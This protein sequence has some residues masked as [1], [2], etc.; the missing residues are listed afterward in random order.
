MKGNKYTIKSGSVFSNTFPDNYYPYPIEEDKEIVTGEVVEDMDVKIE[1][2]NR[3]FIDNMY[4]FMSFYDNPQGIIL[5][6]NQ[7]GLNGKTGESNGGGTDMDN[8]QW[9]NLPSAD[10]QLN[11]TYY[12]QQQPN[13][14]ARH[15][16]ENVY[17]TNLHATWAR[18]GRIASIIEKEIGTFKQDFEGIKLCTEPLSPDA[19]RE[20]DAI[21]EREELLFEIKPY[22]EKWVSDRAKFPDQA[23]PFETPEEVIEFKTTG[24]KDYFA[25]TFLKIAVDNFNNQCWVDYSSKVFM[26][27]RACD[28]TG[29]WHVVENGYNKVKFPQPYNLIVDTR[30]DND[31]LGYDSM[32]AGAI[33]QKTL[34][35]I[36]T[37]YPQFDDEDRKLLWSLATESNAGLGL[38]RTSMC[39]T[40]SWYVYNA[41]YVNGNYANMTIACATV[42]WIAPK[43]IEGNMYQ[44]VYEGTI[45]G[46]RFMVDF[47]ECD[48]IIYN[49]YKTYMPMLPLQI[50]KPNFLLGRFN[51]AIGKIRHLQDD[52]DRLRFK[53]MEMIGKADG[54]IAGIYAAMLEGTDMVTIETQIKQYGFFLLGS[55]GQAISANEFHK[56]MEVWDKRLDPGFSQLTA[57]RG[58]INKEIEMYEGQT[59]VTLGENSKYIGKDAYN[60]SAQVGASGTYN[61]YGMT[62]KF[63]QIQLDYELN[64]KANLYANGF[65]ED[66]AEN[67]IGKK[68]LRLLKKIKG[69]DNYTR[70]FGIAF[71]IDDKIKDA[72]REKMFN[73]VAQRS[74][75]PNSGFTDSDIILLYACSTWTQF[76]DKVKIIEDR[77]KKERAQQ[78]QAQQQMQMQMQQAEQKHQK[79]MAAFD[80]ANKS[81]DNQARVQPKLEKIDL[82]RI[83]HG[84]PPKHENE[85]MPASMLQN[86]GQ[87]PPQP[88]QQ[89]DQQ[90][91]PQPQ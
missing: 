84:L 81:K 73:L 57:F 50:F 27:Q 20:K 53:Q 80:A 52:Y 65:L 7:S 9:W 47:G 62:M 79:E 34:T 45:I 11:L 38:N 6:W 64:V 16:T 85:G 26:E 66:E 51:S 68:G 59:A 2:Y 12:I 72:D 83:E 18:G 10:M 31:P 71:T 61:S 21:I 23:Q 1:K 76:K 32:F 90:Q 15:L 19:K 69:S 74:A 30:I 36:F 49:P 41:N 54:V 67:V 91:P 33:E 28:C 35:Q 89:P 5:P 60:S 3:W 22:F 14:N 13:L 75:N 17:S 39:P 58:E 86:G 87:Q 77:I 63:L 24:I 70:H 78:Q 42:Y 37:D 8:T 40:I 48:N 46:D 25:D 88:E 82:D 56:F 55:T 4:Y 44:T 29:V 43:W